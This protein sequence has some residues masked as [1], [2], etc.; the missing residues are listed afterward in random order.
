[1]R[2]IDKKTVDSKIRKRKERVLTGT[3]TTNVH[4]HRLHQ[5]ASAC[6]LLFTRMRQE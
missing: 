6:N 5:M 4:L 1:M 3:W 2:Q